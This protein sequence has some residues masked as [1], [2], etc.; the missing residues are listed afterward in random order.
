MLPNIDNTVVEF[1]NSEAINISDSPIILV[2]EHASNFI[3]DEFNSLGLNEATLTSHIAWDIGA[4]EMAKHMSKILNASLISA[5]TSRLLYDCN[6]P[7]T[8]PSSIPE[9]SEVFEIAGNQ[10]LSV[11]EREDRATQFYYPFYN[12]VDVTILKAMADGKKPIIITVHTFT[13]Q[14]FGNTRS[15][16]IGIIHDEDSILAEN[17]LKSCTEENIYNIKINEPYGPKDGVTHTLKEHAIRH[18]LLNV[19]IEVRNDLVD[20]PLVMARFLSNNIINALKKVS[21]YAEQSKPR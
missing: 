21:G 10:E 16:E 12:F 15:V 13:P 9:K 18:G 14:Y 8:E 7:P 20:E 4:Y 5:K 6:R 19:M 11:S 17:M 3:P 1:I 2:C